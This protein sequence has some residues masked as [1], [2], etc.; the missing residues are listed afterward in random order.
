M[1]PA[2]HIRSTPGRKSRARCFRPS[3]IERG[4]LNV[5]LFMIVG[6]AGFSILAIFSM[7]VVEKTRDI[8]ILKALGASNRGIHLYF[9]RLRIVAWH[10]R[11]RAGTG[12]GLTI[13]HYLNEIEKF[14]TAV[15]G[16]GDVRREIYYFDEIPTYVKP[17][18]VA[19]LNIGSIAIAV[20]FSVLP[21]LRA[22]LLHPVARCTTNDGR[23]VTTRITLGEWDAHRHESPQKLSS[24]QGRR[25]GAS[26]ARF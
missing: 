20:V 3:T 7:I 15:T 6:V 25:A 2:P 17:A 19:L 23:L 13:T 8:G 18:T 4:I 1:L 14:F 9:P 5:L 26:R 22:A 21:A 11:R 12:L 16:A 10:G 24:R